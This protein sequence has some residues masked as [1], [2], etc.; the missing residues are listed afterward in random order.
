M[1]YGQFFLFLVDTNEKTCLFSTNYKVTRYKVCVDTYCSSAHEEPGSPH[2][3]ACCIPT[4]A[5]YA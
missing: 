5:L 2:L 1:F 3:L 4:S